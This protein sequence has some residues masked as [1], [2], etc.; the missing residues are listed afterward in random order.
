[1]LFN[2]MM[3][4]YISFFCWRAN[5]DISNPLFFKVVS[6]WISL[7]CL[8]FLLKSLVGGSVKSREAREKYD[9]YIG[10]TEGF[11]RQQTILCAEVIAKADLSV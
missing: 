11:L 4:G 2:M 8:L 7:P 6:G 9:K 5:L 10:K 3:F 1:M